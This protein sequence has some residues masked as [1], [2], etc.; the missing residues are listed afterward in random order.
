VTP[1]TTPILAHCLHFYLNIFSS[2][3]ISII[4][5][6]YLE[7]IS[8]HIFD[9]QPPL[10]NKIQ[11]LYN[12]E[13]LQFNQPQ[14]K[15][16]FNYL[17]DI[18]PW[19]YLDLSFCAHL[20]HLQNG[21]SNVYPHSKYSVYSIWYNSCFIYAQFPHYSLIQII[22]VVWPV[23]CMSP[24]CLFAPSTRSSFCNSHLNYYVLTLHLF[25]SKSHSF[26][27]DKLSFYLI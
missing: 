26:F 16:W 9:T 21:K 23:L 5:N 7:T 27:K 8:W 25:I 17:Q 22:Y 19:A 4:F 1:Y 10:Y 2:S 20:P 11:W 14:C 6:L 18:W 24:S 15:S 12:T 3:L 13:G